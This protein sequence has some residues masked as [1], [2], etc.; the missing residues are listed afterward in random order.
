[1]IVAFVHTK[2]GVGKTTSAVMV[3]AAAAATGTAVALYDADPQRSACRW[4]EIAE[5]CGDPLP[6]SVVPATAK[7][8]SGLKGSDDLTI[9]DT[10][11]GTAKEIQAA[12]DVAD[13]V[14]VPS[15]ASPMDIDRVW[16]TLETTSHRMTGVLLTGVLMHTRMYSEA[17]DLLENQGVPTFY[18]AVP[19]R[20]DMKAQ[21]GTSPTK[22]HGY[23]DVY[24][25]I[26][27]IEEME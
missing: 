1:M 22:L 12:I 2:G 25:E 15:G 13:L 24:K 4:A 8:L 7:T 5:Q 27:E 21:F 9:I 3:A 6:F 17:R 19:Q 11:P 18:N 14:V 10:P 20:E 26:A 23:D 16:P